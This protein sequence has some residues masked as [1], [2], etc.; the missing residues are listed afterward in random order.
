MSQQDLSPENFSPSRRGLLRS[1]SAAAALPFVASL[2]ALHARE[3]LAAG[4]NTALVDSLYGPIAPVND[5]T[6]G[7][8]LLQLPP[9][10][11]YKSFG[12]TGDLMSN[13]KPCPA[14]HDGM[15]VVATRKVGRSTEIV[16]VRNH[17]VG[18]GSDASFFGAPAVYDTGSGFSNGGT[19]NLVFRDGAFLRIDAN[20]GGTRTNCA[21]GIT[22]WGTW[23]TCEEVGSDSISNAGRKHGYVFECAADPAQTTGQPI[24]GMG[25]F[26]HEAV[27]IDPSTGIAYLT[28]D[29]SGK[30]GFYRYIPDV[31]PGTIGSLAQGG[32]LQMAKVK[33]RHNVNVAPAQ[34]DQAYELEW[35]DIVDPDRNRGNA[36]GPEGA[37]IS[38]ASGPF[39]QGWNQGALRMNRGEGIWYFAG[40]MYV[41]DTSGGSINRGAIWELELATQT[42]TC[43][44]ST[45]STTV[46]NMGDN[47][48]VSPRGGL[49][50]CED[51]GGVTDMFGFGERLMG[52]TDEGSAYI[53]AKNNYNVTA[54]QLAA[55]GK[56]TS[57]AGDRRGTEF[58]GA[59]FDPT[60]RYLF[61]NQ[62]T[63][64]ITFA[65]TGPWAKGP[66]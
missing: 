8:P 45:A 11:S 29:S 20:L 47:L 17:E 12:W 46:G 35:V 52:L 28:E 5:L 66:L 53:F 18:T 31:L 58:C 43:I 57:L 63:P 55:A 19:T 23:L 7:L 6:T 30:S 9:G 26:A 48:T 61:V 1:A 40:K 37:T 49:L 25:R 4:G 16:L 36:T 21:G 3:A 14:A 10:F 33:E 38:N 54:A 39:V 44:Y 34:L 65:I 24:I 56:R 15:G 13:G 59:C 41:M 64:G 42:L 2:G 32:K 60:G 51:G 50:I 22:P 62:Q 27:A